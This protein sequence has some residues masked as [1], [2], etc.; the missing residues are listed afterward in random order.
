M[1]PVENLNKAN[2]NIRQHNLMSGIFF[3]ILSAIYYEAKNLCKQNNLA[4]LLGN[5]IGDLCEFTMEE[6]NM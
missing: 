6:M 1:F 2:I 3:C 5:N 4:F